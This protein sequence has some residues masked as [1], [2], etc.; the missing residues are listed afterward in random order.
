MSQDEGSLIKSVGGI[1]TLPPKKP[2]QY[3]TLLC[4]FDS[5]E[6][7][8]KYKRWLRTPWKRRRFYARK[9]LS[10]YTSNRSQKGSSKRE[11]STEDAP[12]TLPSPWSTLAAHD[13]EH[14]NLACRTTNAKQARYKHTSVRLKLLTYFCLF[15]SSYQEEATSARANLL[16]R[17]RNWRE[18][19]QASSNLKCFEKK[20]TTRGCCYGNAF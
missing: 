4:C 13:R 16:L 14:F 2:M 19:E 9:K 18:S 5:V 20:T 12:G 3:I 8:A 11:S 15:H 17:S 6:E 7:G 1:P 10:V